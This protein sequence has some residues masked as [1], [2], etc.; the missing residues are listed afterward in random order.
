MLRRLLI[1]PLLA[2]SF[3]LAGCGERVEVPAAHVGKVMTKDG[4]KESVYP[5]SKF[6]LEPCVM[7]CDKLVLLNVSDN[8]FNE[9][10]QLFMPKD[11]LNMSFTLQMTLAVRDSSYDSIFSRITPT[12]AD[13]LDYIPVERVYTTYAQQIIRAEAREFLSQFTISEIAS[14]RES[15]NTELSQRMTETI[16]KRTPFI[17]RYAGLSDLKYPEIIVQAQENAAQRREMIQQEEAQLEISKVQ[18]ERQLQEQRLQRAIDVERAEAEAQVN[19]ILAQSVTPEYLKYRSLNALDKIA[20]SENKVFIPT[21]MLNTVASQ[22]L[23]G[24]Q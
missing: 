3:I 1:L 16:N 13:G 11:R 10:M 14:S 5:T 22:V 7:Y 4:Y 17:V 21:E 15:I 20:D 24:S 18:L 23:L 9:T 2:F 8:A 6:R 12:H 19:K